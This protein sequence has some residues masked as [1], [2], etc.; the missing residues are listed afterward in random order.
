MERKVTY[1]DPVPVR[2]GYQ[3]PS[4]SKRGGTRL[5][6]VN[7]GVINM[8]ASQQYLRT[9]DGMG[10]KL[11]DHVNPQTGMYS[12]STSNLESLPNYEVGMSQPRAEAISGSPTGTLRQLP[13]KTL[14]DNAGN[15]VY[16]DENGRRIR[17]TDMGEDHGIA[18][19]RGIAPSN[20]TKPSKGSRNVAARAPKR[21]KPM[22][23]GGTGVAGRITDADVETFI[24]AVAKKRGQTVTVITPNMMRDG[25]EALKILRKKA[26]QVLGQAGQ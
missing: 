5:N 10:Q 6:P 23:P 11:R 17:T 13:A 3:T 8:E 19:P 15:R 25:R 9:R 20:V 7:D 18:V 16:L 22:V 24:H 14:V 12:H 26:A 2:Y 21:A 4:M 1:L